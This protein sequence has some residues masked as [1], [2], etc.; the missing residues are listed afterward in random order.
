MVQFWSAHTNL[1]CQLRLTDALGGTFY[2]EIIVHQ[3][4][5]VRGEFLI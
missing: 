2:S 3:N 1:L 4:C 5:A